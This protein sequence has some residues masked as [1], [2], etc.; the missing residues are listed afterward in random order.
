MAGEPFA[1]QAAVHS[2]CAALVA[3]A[4]VSVGFST[5]E[6]AVTLYDNGVAPDGPP[7]TAT[8]PGSGRRPRS[9]RSP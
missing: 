9:G 5:G 2:T 3:G 6:P 8:S 1:L 4:S 7:A